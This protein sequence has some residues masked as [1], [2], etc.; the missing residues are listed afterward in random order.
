MFRSP[1]CFS[2]DLHRVLSM[3]TGYFGFIQESQF[4]FFVSY[5]N[6]SNLSNLFQMPCFNLQPIVSSLCKRLRSC[7]G[8]RVSLLSPDEV[9]QSGLFEHLFLHL[10]LF[11]AEA[12]EFYRGLYWF[13]VAHQGRF[14]DGSIVAVESEFNTLRIHVLRNFPSW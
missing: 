12:L 8:I 14:L 6:H 5:F 4:F 11:Q 1:H 3:H 9:S 2:Q 13:P 7:C 10:F